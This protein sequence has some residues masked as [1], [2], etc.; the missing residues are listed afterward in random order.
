MAP[1]ILVGF[2]AVEFE[3]V[4]SGFVT[5]VYPEFAASANAPI[6][7][8]R[9]T[10]SGCLPLFG[11]QMFVNLGSNVAGSVLGGVA[12]LFCGFAVGFWRFG[13]RLR[14]KSRFA[15]GQVES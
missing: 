14:E 12:V 11:R 9:S 15:N 5:D 13:K 7:F 2:V 10:V 6:T 8:V 3:Y 4:L 1:L